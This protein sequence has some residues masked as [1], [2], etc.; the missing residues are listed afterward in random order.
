MSNIGRSLLLL[1]H[2][3]TETEVL[4]AISAV[5]PEQMMRVAS[6]SVLLPH[7]ASIVGRTAE[8]VPAEWLMA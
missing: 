1:D 6:A 7:S 8:Q 4:D 5:T 2:V 3:R